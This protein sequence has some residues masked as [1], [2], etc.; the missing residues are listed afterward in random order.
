MRFSHWEECVLLLAFCTADLGRLSVSNAFR[1]AA[2]RDSD[3][4]RLRYA[5]RCRPPLFSLTL[6]HLLRYVF[7]FSQ[8][9]S[10]SWQV[11]NMRC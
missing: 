1:S 8:A 10:C 3:Q 9:L 4:L 5:P 2:T 7:F 6:R 11:E